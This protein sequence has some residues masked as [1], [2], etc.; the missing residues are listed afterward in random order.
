MG[1]DC[2]ARMSGAKCGI[3]EYRGCTAHPG[4]L[5][6]DPFCGPIWSI[7]LRR[8]VLVPVKLARLL[9]AQPMLAY[10]FVV[11][12]NGATQIEQLGAMALT[13]DGEALVFGKQII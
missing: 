10:S 1:P 4:Y 11:R 9:S 3:P 12:N 2:V 6:S 13:N 5:F 7:L 8:R